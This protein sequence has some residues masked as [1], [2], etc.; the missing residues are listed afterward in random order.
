[1]S[2]YGGPAVHV[3][4]PAGPF[5]VPHEPQVRLTHQETEALG[6]VRQAAVIP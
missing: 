2:G 4:A 3:D 1:M 6:S 5:F